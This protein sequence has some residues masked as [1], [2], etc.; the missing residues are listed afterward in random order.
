[1][2]V[3]RHFFFSVTLHLFVAQAGLAGIVFMNQLR[4]ELEFSTILTVVCFLHN[5]LFV[6][7]AN[8]VIKTTIIAVDVRNVGEV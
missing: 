6:E 4:V 8:Y 2:P 3:Y 7:V 5:T 1:M